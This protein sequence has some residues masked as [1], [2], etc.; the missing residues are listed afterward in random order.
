[1][2]NKTSH[3]MIQEKGGNSYFGATPIWIYSHAPAGGG[4]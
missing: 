1:M 2:S 4:Y 3:R